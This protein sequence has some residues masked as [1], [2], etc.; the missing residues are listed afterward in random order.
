MKLNNSCVRDIV[1]LISDYNKYVTEEN[2]LK[3]FD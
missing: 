3:L 2:V 1:N